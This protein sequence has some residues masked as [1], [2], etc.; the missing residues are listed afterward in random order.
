MYVQAG[1]DPS[2]FEKT[3]TCESYDPWM[4]ELRV[5]AA[6][7]MVMRVAD[8]HVVSAKQRAS[9]GA[10][11][12]KTLLTAPIVVAKE[13]VGLLTLH[14]GSANDPIEN[15]LE[16]IPM[17]AAQVALAFRLA[18]VRADRRQ[19]TS[20]AQGE[21]AE[22]ERG[23]RERGTRSPD[24]IERFPEGRACSSSPDWMGPVRG[25]T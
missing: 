3:S 5:R 14:L 2:A 25:Q 18:R 11:G 21:V 16:L 13:K 24:A 10:L 12:I 22:H 7:P 17:F 1:G 20:P 8:D 23:R 19:A 9:L 6:L 15:D 4:R